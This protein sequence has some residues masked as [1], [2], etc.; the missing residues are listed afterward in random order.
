[1]AGGGAAP[2]VKSVTAGKTAQF[3]VYGNGYCLHCGGDLISDGYRR[4]HS[5]WRDIRIA[6]TAQQLRA[7]KEVSWSGSQLSSQYSLTARCAGVLGWMFSA[8]QN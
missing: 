2:R 1:M 6:A 4:A 8:D 7:S 3:P 5:A